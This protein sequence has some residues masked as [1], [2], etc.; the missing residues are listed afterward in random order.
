MTSEETELRI[1]DQYIQYIRAQ[2]ASAPKTHSRLEFVLTI[3]RWVL[4]EKPL[5]ECMRDAAESRIRDGLAAAI[6]LF[7]DITLNDTSRVEGWY[8]G[9]T[10]SNGVERLARVLA[11][12]IHEF[13][14]AL[15]YDDVSTEARPE[16]TQ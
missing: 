16:V 13:E 9:R 1:C 2:S 10:P 5:P 14:Q 15:L 7:R 6:A 3:Y 11:S 12:L 8:E 4:F